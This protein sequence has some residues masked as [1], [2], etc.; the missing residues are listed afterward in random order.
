VVRGQTVSGG[1]AAMSCLTATELVGACVV[2]R[3]K[4]G[5]PS[6][7]NERKKRKGRKKRKN[8]KLQPIGTA[9]SSFLLNSS[10]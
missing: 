3:A 6:Q 5:N 1:G 2:Y 10:S 9:L 4:R 8:R 7:R